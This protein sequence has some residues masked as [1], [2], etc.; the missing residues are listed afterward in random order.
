MSFNWKCGL[1]GGVMASVV[2]TA[3]LWW[4]TKDFP[5][6]AGFSPAQ[7]VIGVGIFCLVFLPLVFVGGLYEA[8]RNLEID[9]ML[10]DYKEKKGIK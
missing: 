9:E 7:V 4:L 5:N 10:D 1:I 2:I 8:D 3:T 6:M